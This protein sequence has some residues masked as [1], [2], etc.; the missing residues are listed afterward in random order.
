MLKN[1]RFRT[2]GISAKR[3]PKFALAICVS[4]LMTHAL[5]AAYSGPDYTQFVEPF[6]NPG[7]S[8]AFHGADVPHGTIM[9]DPFD[10]NGRY[11]Y[12]LFQLSGASMGDMHSPAYFAPSAANQGSLTQNLSVAGYHH[13]K[14]T[15]LETEITATC[16]TA[17]CRFTVAAN[18]TLSISIHASGGVTRIDEYTVQ[19]VATYYNHPA[20]F[21]Y[22]FKQPI[23]A[24]SGSTVQIQASGTTPIE[25]KISESLFDYAHAQQSLD[26]ENPGWNFDLVRTAA[27]DSWNT[28]FSRL[29]VEGSDSVKRDF[30]TQLFRVLVHENIMSETDGSYIFMQDVG[31]DKPKKAVL[32]RA[33]GFT[34][35]ANVSGWD[36]WRT[37]NQ[38]MGFVY[39]DRANDMAQSLIV[40]GSFLTGYRMSSLPVWTV[41]GFETNVMGGCGLAGPNMAANFYAFGARDFAAK[42]LA[43]PLLLKDTTVNMGKFSNN[44]SEVVEAGASLFCIAQ[45]AAFMGDT[46]TYRR[47]MKMA[48]RW[49]NYIGSAGLTGG[50]GCEDP[51]NIYSW[52]VPWNMTGLIRKRGGATAA[53]VSMDAAQVNGHICNEPE[54]H[55]PFVYNWIG[56][57]WKTQKAVHDEL[58]NGVYPGQW[59]D[60]DLGAMGSWAV[61]CM[62]GIYPAIYA[63]PGFTIHA[64]AVTKA[65]ITYGKGTGRKL[66]IIGQ[67]ASSANYYVQS[68]TLNGNPWTSTW[69]PVEALTLDSNT[70][71]IN[72]GAQQSTWGSRPQDAPPSFDES[73]MPV[74]A[75][76]PVTNMKSAAHTNLRVWVGQSL[77]MSI[78]SAGPHTLRIY[79]VDGSLVHS[80]CGTGS[81]RYSVSRSLLT[82]NA[83]VVEALTAQGKEVTRTTVTR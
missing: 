6:H 25:M 47:V 15:G 10:Q 65:T 82:E 11:S 7:N 56:K 41:W 43:L 20:Y 40:E 18:A 73:S 59:C 14:Y 36:I 75:R 61:W 66:T 83:Y 29:A 70:L 55:M 23:G 48:G 4:L 31:W 57:P 68:V 78:G 38:L 39:T 58:V 13:V 53:E 24:L 46:L 69:L 45:Y 1:S 79:S 62:M 32:S 12:A 74:A 64:P 8:N 27:R 51:L 16:R 49:T 72:C 67:N 35:Y 2:I 34:Y 5:T 44:G 17:H 60:D 37:W 81:Q 33:T 63:V 3:M 21:I 54:F 80:I 50:D 42:N 76:N 52:M 77:N 19:G 30:Y 26:A 71:V 22:K 28:A 9:V